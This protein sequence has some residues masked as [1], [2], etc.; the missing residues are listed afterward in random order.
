MTQRRRTNLIKALEAGDGRVVIE[1]NGIMQIAKSYFEDLFTSR[2]RLT[3]MLFIL[4]RV[5]RTITAE[6]N[7]EL[8]ATFTKVEV[9]EAFK[10]IRPTNAP[11]FDGFLAIFY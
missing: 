6:D 7:F 1:Q 8:N 5:D 2:N 10:K 9:F 4:S 11:S 3:G